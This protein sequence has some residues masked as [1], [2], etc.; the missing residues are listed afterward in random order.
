M[1]N[2]K[3]IGRRKKEYKESRTNRIRTEQ[4]KRKDDNI[5]VRYFFCLSLIKPY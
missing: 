4:Q 1:G 5:I 2:E 3:R